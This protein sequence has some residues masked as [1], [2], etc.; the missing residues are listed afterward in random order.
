MRVAFLWG[1]RLIPYVFNSRNH[2]KN[3]IDR[4]LLKLQGRQEQARK[5]RTVLPLMTVTVVLLS[6]CMIFQDR[7]KFGLQDCL[8]KVMY[9]SHVTVN[10]PLSFHPLPPFR[11]LTTTLKRARTH[12]RTYPLCTL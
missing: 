5:R 8:S 3:E 9:F 4:G 12:T 7:E 2:F 11:N 1:T 6:L 10:R